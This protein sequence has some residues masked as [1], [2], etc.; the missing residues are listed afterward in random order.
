MKRIKCSGQMAD[1]P[2]ELLEVWIDQIPPGRALLL[3]AGKGEL[4]KWL[5]ARGFQVDAVEKDRSACDLMRK[6]CHGLDVQVYSMD[7]VDFTYQEAHY[8]LIVALAV[9]HFLLPTDL[10][11]LVDRLPPSIE[12]G[13]I[14]IAEVFTIDDPGY[15]ALVEAAIPQIQPNTFA[16]PGSFQQLHYFEPGELRRIFGSLAVLFYEEARRRD[17]ID[18]RGLRAGASL[19]AR[20]E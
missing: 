19:V 6:A 10:W 2:S 18:P 11:R 7:L 13:G 15:D 8:C 17:G 9:L 20:K 3:G 4:A 16:L 14:L 12:P 1:S 5:A